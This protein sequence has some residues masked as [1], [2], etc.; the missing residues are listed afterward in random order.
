M[1]QPT[2]RPLLRC[3]TTRLPGPVYRQYAYPYL[4]HQSKCLIARALSLTH[5]CLPTRCQQVIEALLC[6]RTPPNCDSEFIIVYVHVTASGSSKYT[7]SFLARVPANGY[8]TYFITA[9]PSHQSNEAG[10]APATADIVVEDT[11]VGNGVFTLSISGTTGRITAL[12]NVL[13]GVTV[14]FTQVR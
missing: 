6:A 1:T 8:S 4:L 14:P 12:K 2:T 11:I 3:C 9:V 7:V 5:R 13:S 10:E